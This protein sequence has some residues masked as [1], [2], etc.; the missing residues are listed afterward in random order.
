MTI[1]DFIISPGDGILLQD[2]LKILKKD[3]KLYN[4]LYEGFKEKASWG[5]ISYRDIEYLLTTGEKE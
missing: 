5:L 2:A 4:K 3:E 1:Q